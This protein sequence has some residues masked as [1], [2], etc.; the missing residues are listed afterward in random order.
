MNIFRNMK[1]TKTVGMS[2]FAALFAGLLCLCSQAVAQDLSDR[3]GR[4]YGENR[5]EHK[6]SRGAEGAAQNG[7][8]QAAVQDVQNKTQRGAAVVMRGERHTSAARRS[9]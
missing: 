3:Q 1:T 5:V 6:R 7:S 8:K 4:P 2:V 9:A